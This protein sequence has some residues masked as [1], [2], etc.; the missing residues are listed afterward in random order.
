MKYGEI[1]KKKK[2]VRTTVPTSCAP[3]LFQ[4]EKRDICESRG[5]IS[6]QGREKL[7]VRQQ[8][9]G[10]FTVSRKFFFPMRTVLHTELR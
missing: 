9:G 8:K 6:S 2:E 10:G 3:S 4:E 7:P 1:D 5:A